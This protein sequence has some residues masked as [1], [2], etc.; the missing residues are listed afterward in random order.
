[1]TREQVKTFLPEYADKL[2]LMEYQ[3][4]ANLNTSYSPSAGRLFD[5]VSALLGIA[6]ERISYEGQAAIRLEAA[7]RK[8]TAGESGFVPYVGQEKEGV[9]MIDWTPLFGDCSMMRRLTAR[10]FHESVADAALS[11]VE[12][13]LAKREGSLKNPPVIL[14]GGVFQNRLLTELVT[15]RLA[16]RGMEV[17]I[18]RKVP[19][20]DGGISV[21]Q[22]LW[23]GLQFRI[24]G[25]NYTV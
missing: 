24:S 21:G 1:M 17:F 16:S 11:M 19:P 15:A 14:T 25:V 3:C 5:A 6:P 2:E 13:A 4:I 10:G 22:A 20:N 12:F 8:E 18:P 9:F 23:S 7:A